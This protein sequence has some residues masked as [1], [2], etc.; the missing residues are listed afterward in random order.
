M[1]FSPD[2][3]LFVTQANEVQC[4]NLLI[5]ISLATFILDVKPLTHELTLESHIFR[6]IF[7]FLHNVVCQQHIL[8]DSSCN[9]KLWKAHVVGTE[10][11]YGLLA[12]SYIYIY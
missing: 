5:C 4:Q 10:F 6:L 1:A 7:L 3:M 11:N 9:V 12:M 8:L 2:K